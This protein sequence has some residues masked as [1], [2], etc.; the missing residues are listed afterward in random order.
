MPRIHRLRP[1]TH[2]PQASLADMAFLLLI[3]FIATTT[4]GEEYGLLLTLP[5]GSRSAA[6]VPVRRENV[7]VITTDPSGDRFFADDEPVELT[8]LRDIIRARQ[9]AEPALIVSV[10][11]D[12]SAPYRAMID[13][14][15]ELKLAGA[16]NIS[17]RTRAR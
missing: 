11:P 10:E 7:L 9:A 13:I 14:L 3:F 16:R 4:I 8:R 6:A 12:R 15:D 5:A 2:I 17:L 1:P